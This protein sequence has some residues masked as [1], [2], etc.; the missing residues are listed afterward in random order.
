MSHNIRSSWTMYTVWSLINQSNLLM[1]SSSSTS[2]VT[3]WNLKRAT[4]HPNW[5]MLL[6][7]SK[8]PE[9]ASLS[10]SWTRKQGQIQ[11]CQ[12]CPILSHSSFCL[13]GG[14]GEERLAAQL[15]AMSASARTSSTLH[16]L[17]MYSCKESLPPF[18]DQ[19]GKKIHSSVLKPHPLTHTLPAFFTAP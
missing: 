12:L 10:T 17:T 5:R 3:Y 16:S 15:C 13:G 8:S 7:S 4:F 2:Q 9:V 11:W 19:V 14:G 1:M 18:C 6:F